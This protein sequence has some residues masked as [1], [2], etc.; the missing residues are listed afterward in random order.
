MQ[1][2]H[3]FVLALETTVL[4]C[5]LELDSHLHCIVNEIPYN[6]IPMAYPQHGVYLWYWAIQV[7]PLLLWA[8]KILMNAALISMQYQNSD[9]KMD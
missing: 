5:G 6:R 8:C 1:N 7:N 4:V 2:L 9:V 3:N